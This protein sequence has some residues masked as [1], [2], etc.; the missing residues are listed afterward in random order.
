[1]KGLF[2]FISTFGKQVLILLCLSPWVSVSLS[3]G[4]FVEKVF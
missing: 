1:M 2:D 4:V 3:L